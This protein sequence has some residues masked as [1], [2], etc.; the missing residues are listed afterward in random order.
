MP[1]KKKTQEE[2]E[3]LM[4]IT[5]MKPSL[6]SDGHKFHGCLMDVNPV[7]TPLWKV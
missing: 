7:C 6:E 4:F 2:N 5:E 3:N 1:P